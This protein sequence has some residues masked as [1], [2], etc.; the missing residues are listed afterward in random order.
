MKRI[1][2]IFS[3]YKYQKSLYKQKLN[4]RKCT[5]EIR[6]SFIGHLVV[7]SSYKYY[8]MTT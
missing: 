6:L 3:C 1:F 8:I 4:V 7:L 5:Y 2:V